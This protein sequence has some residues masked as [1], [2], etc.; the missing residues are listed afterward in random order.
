YTHCW[1]SAFWEKYLG[2]CGWCTSRDPQ[3]SPA[4]SSLPPCP[5]WRVSSDPSGTRSP[6][7]CA[8]I[9]FPLAPAGC[10]TGAASRTD[11]RRSK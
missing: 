3:V 10:A 5:R 1:W 11:A 7:R 9:A 2:R 8:D 4:K 6:G